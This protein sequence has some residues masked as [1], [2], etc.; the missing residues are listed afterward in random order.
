MKKLCLHIPLEHKP[1]QFPAVDVV[2]EKVV[3][4]TGAQFR[5]LRNHPLDDHEEI[6]KVKPY[7]W[8]DGKQAHCV[9]FLNNESR[10]G[11][12]VE[13]QGYDYARYAAFV[14]NARDIVGTAEFSTADWNLREMVQE[15][16]QE[17]AELAHRGEREFDTETMLEKTFCNP[18]QLITAAVM[19]ALQ[20]REDIHMANLTTDTCIHAEPMPL[21]SLTIYSPVTFRTAEPSPRTIT[22]ETACQAMTELQQYLD[23]QLEVDKKRGFMEAHDSQDSLNEKVYSAMPRFE[24]VDGALMLATSCRVAAPLTLLEINELKEGIREQLEYHAG[25][26][27]YQKPVETP[28][29]A[30]RV[31]FWTDS[32]E[33]SMQTAEELDDAEPDEGE[34]LTEPSM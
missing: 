5:S 29:G 11:I 22:P 26:V 28:L 31:Y 21:Q 12:L 34:E 16:A 4:L 32:P 27:D 3:T 2:V 10:D 20:S 19:A 25:T 23:S 14:P 1:E 13:S 9:L 33:W 18:T 24:I 30:L 6:A 7:M 8:S 17:I 15:I